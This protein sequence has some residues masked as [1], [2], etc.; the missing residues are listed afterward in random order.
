M[1]AEV[2]FILFS[3]I[4]PLPEQCMTRSNNTTNEITFLFSMLT[5]L[6]RAKEKSIHEDKFFTTSILEAMYSKAL[7]LN[8]IYSPFHNIVYATIFYNPTTLSPKHT[9]HILLLSE[10]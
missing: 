10:I 7:V 8:I 9:S 5:Y 4:S 2:F 1:K 3:A 6:L